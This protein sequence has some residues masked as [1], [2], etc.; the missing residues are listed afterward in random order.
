MDEF[1]ISTAVH[2]DFALDTHPS[3]DQEIKV[4]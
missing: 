4:S 3:K 1:I 2:V